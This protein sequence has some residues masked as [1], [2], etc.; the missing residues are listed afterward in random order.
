MVEPGKTGYLS[1]Y[2]EKLANYIYDLI[3]NEEKLLALK[4]DCLKKNEEINNSSAY[5]ELIMR[6]YNMQFV[7]NG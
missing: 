1:E 2:D 7:D 5:K 4:K 6:Q 3:I